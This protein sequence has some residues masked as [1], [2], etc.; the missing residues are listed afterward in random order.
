MEIRDKKLIVV[1]VGKR[2]ANRELLGFKLYSPPTNQQDLPIFYWLSSSNDSLSL[3]S[4]SYSPQKCLPH[5]FSSL[6]QLSSSQSFL[7]SQAINHAPPVTTYRILMPRISCW[8]PT[9]KVTTPAHSLIACCQKNL[10]KSGKQCS[11]KKKK[12]T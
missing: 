7:A 10:L 8:F 5:N 11:K 12:K 2:L 6:L 4:I 9:G 3:L 1:I